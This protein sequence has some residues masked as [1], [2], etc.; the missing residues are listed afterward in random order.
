MTR[1]LRFAVLSF[2]LAAGA[3][4][5]LATGPAEAAP[6]GDAR[7][8][9]ALYA[10]KC[11]V[12]H[13][14]SGKGDGPAEFV[15]FPKPRDLTSGK[16]KIRSTTT[17]PTDHDLFRV[18]TQGIPG[19]AMP[20]WT[21]LSEAQRW[22]LVAYVKSLSPVFAQQKAAKP[23]VIPPTPKAT[24]AML[25]TG[26]K[27]Y[28]EAE[29]LKCHGATGKGDGESADTLKDEWGSPI[30]PYDFTIAG[31]MKGGNTVRDVYRTLLNG[32]GGTPMPSF[33]DSLSPEEIWG[34][35]YYVMSLAKDQPR[36]AP[37]EAGA[38]RVK[39]VAG[40]IA[41]D[42]TAAA[43]R[44]AALQPVSLRTLWLR[45]QQVTQLRVAA[46]HNGKEIGF[47][48]EW[49]DPLADQAALGVE[50]FR[51]AAAVQLPLGA[52]KGANPEASYVMGDAKQPVN[53]WHWKSDWQLDVA[54]YRDREDRY[55]A[56]AVDDM[57]FV[58]GVRSSSPEAA[59]APADAHDPLFLA[60]RAAG[61]P[62]SRPRRS[63]VENVNAAG[64]G[65]ITSQP[66][67]F[68]VIRG[69]GRWAEGKWRVVM[70]RGLR[71]ENPRDAQLQPGQESAVAFAVWDGAR[72]DRDGQKAVSV[73]QRLLL[74]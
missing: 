69:D 73:W 11:A 10:Q 62:M 68:Q 67:E 25:E 56:L 59:V 47:L 30:V 28:A 4:W 2:T 55:A 54:R 26:K 8:G 40:E 57:P 42:P 52:G 60:G 6:R 64:V 38:V 44:G 33:A 3:P 7:K 50:Q 20:S 45:P 71:T 34:L 5:G 15:L 35:A 24:P 27:F 1:T 32:I 41:A 19:T 63:A 29:C 43:W 22:D 66:A 61:N 51:D 37:A 72:R 46:L 17:M 18:V 13:G 14:Q 36:Q 48:L 16:F 21:V 53:I 74:Q 65:T 31:R 23:G 49:D 70:V 58:R 12:C 9:Q 39:R